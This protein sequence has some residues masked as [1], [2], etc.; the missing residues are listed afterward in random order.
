M[1]TRRKV[2]NAG[3]MSLSMPLVMFSATKGFAE[4]TQDSSVSFRWRVPLAHREAVRQALPADVQE[5]EDSDAKGVL[6]IIVGAV[7]LTYLAKAILALRRDI[8]HGGVVI[9]LRRDPVEIETDKGLSGGVILVIAPDGKHT[10]YERDE[11]E[12]PTEL[13]NALISEK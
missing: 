12:S 2:L 13:I 11:I 3:L 6:Y 7:V 10:L 5:I 1:I 9:D 4:I 8:V